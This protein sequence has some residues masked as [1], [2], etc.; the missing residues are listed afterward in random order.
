ME[1]LLL[2]Y[3]I[4]AVLNVAMFG[5]VWIAYHTPPDLA[6]ELRFADK[7]ISQYALCGV[8]GS[9]LWIVASPVF[10]YLLTQ[11]LMQSG[12]TEYSSVETASG[13]TSAVEVDTEHTGQI[14]HREE[15]EQKLHQTG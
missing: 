14:L 3:T 2:F 10:G 13:S 8:I 5:S 12:E 9:P 7:K 15:Y 6:S 1:A 11:R 4:A